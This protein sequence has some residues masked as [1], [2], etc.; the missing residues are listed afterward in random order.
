[1]DKERFTCIFNDVDDLHYS[2]V[3][4]E[5]KE[6][7]N[8]DFQLALKLQKEFD[9]IWKKEAMVD[10]KKGTVDAYLLR[11]T[12]NN[13]TSTQSS[14]SKHWNFSCF[15][16]RWR[17]IDKFFHSDILQSNVKTNS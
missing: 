12:D 4:N 10:R 16:A 6:Q 2:Q 14:S 7:E 3:L 17:M 1:M 8:Q 9:S 15:Q 5:K 11:K 13:S